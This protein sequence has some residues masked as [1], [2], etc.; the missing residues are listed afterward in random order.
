MEFLKVKIG[1]KIIS[2][3]DEPIMLIL[4]DQDKFNISHMH[5]S[6]YKYCSY[7]SN[8]TEEDVVQFMYLS[9]KD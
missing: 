3:E 7:P 2:S 1:N 4:T 6:S 9:K 5:P 8:M